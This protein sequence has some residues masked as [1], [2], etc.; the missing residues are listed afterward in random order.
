MKTLFVLLFSILSFSIYS[1]DMKLR[2]KDKKTNYDF[3]KSGKFVQ[4]IKHPKASPG[5]FMI[6][7]DSIKYEYSENGKYVTKSMIKFTKPDTFESIAYETN[8]PGFE[9]HMNEVIETKIIQTS[10]Q[11]SLIRT[12]ERINKGKWHNFVMR[13][14]TN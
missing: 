4:K 12:K 13:K 5:Y 10:T 2:N 14:V 11:D 7:K 8:R 6:I 9:C 1:Q 3:F